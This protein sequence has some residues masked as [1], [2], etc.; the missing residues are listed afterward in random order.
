MSRRLR[1]FTASLT[2]TVLTL[3][4]LAVQADARIAWLD[5]PG[6]SLSVVDDDGVSERAVV[7]SQVTGFELAPRGDAVVSFDEAG[8]MWL[9]VLA[10]A[11]PVRLSGG[12]DVRG[13]AWSPDGRELAIARLQ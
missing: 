11:A 8:A 9:R 7:A 12:D 10:D 4:S 3:F 13:V 1:V 6:G 5:A 2:V